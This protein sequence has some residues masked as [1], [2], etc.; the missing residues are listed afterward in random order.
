MVFSR[1]RPLHL[2]S[3]LLQM[4]LKKYRFLFKEQVVGMEMHPAVP[5]LDFGPKQP[6]KRHWRVVPMLSTV[7]FVCALR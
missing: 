6:I 7:S 2:L 4:R 3:D 1:M 5:E